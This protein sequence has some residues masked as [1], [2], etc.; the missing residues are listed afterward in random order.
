MKHKL[1]E[2]ITFHVSRFTLEMYKIPCDI[3]TGFL[4]SGKTTLLK[5]VLQRGLNKRRVAIVMNELGDLGVDGKVIKDL[6]AVEKLVELDNGCICCSIGLRFALAIQEIVDTTNPELIIIETTGVAEPQPLIQEL[7]VAGLTLDAIITVV[8][9]ENILGIHSQSVVTEKQIEPA[10]FIVLNKTDLVD[11][12]YLHKVEKYLQKLNDRALILPSSYGQI[13]TDLIFGTSVR[14]YRENLRVSQDSDHNYHEKEHTHLEQDEITAF[15]YKGGQLME[16]KKFERFLSELPPAIYRAKGFIKF[17][18][19]S[20][21]S[22]F[23]YTCGRF[24]FNWYTLKDGEQIKPQAV[25]IGKN[26]H[27]IKDKVLKKL[28]A[29]EAKV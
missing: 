9:A 3:V 6:E 22:L 23:N 13:K 7:G 24:D 14:G 29:C 8:D 25:F 18:N 19:E 4:G 10:D 28:E 20:M 2:I 1:Q 12:R 21:P 16:R 15:L 17:T 27:V 5:Y 11:E 26:V